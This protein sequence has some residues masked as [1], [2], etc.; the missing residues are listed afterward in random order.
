MTVRW[1]EMVATSIGSF[2]GWLDQSLATF[3]S[4]KGDSGLNTYRKGS[5]RRE[6][7]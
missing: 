6:G 7:F 5:V 3:H 4:F 1:T 2:S